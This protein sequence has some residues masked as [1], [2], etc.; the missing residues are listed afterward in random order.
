[1]LING[2]NLSWGVTVIVVTLF[3]MTDR[4][5][6]RGSG[7]SHHNSRSGGNSG[8]GFGFILSGLTC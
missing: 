3:G 4:T 6:I 8:R 1:M 5:G 7:G 2:L